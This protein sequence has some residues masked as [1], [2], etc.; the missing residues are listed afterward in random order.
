MGTRTDGA[1]P[2]EEGQIEFQDCRRME[3]LNRNP[4]MTRPTYVYEL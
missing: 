4:A 1:L 2:G 3:G